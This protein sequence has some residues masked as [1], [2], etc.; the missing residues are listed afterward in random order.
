ME[1][2]LRKL[3]M[4]IKKD[5]KFEGFIQWETQS[6]AIRN[7]E[8]YLLKNDLTI[9]IN[10]KVQAERIL[11]DRASRDILLQMANDD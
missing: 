8:K 5:H 1:R 4:P 9:N 11:A 7:L 3:G 6:I 2:K 10:Y